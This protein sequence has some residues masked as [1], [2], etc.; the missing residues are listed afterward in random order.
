MK[1]EAVKARL[2]EINNQS[3]KLQLL[4]SGVIV[5][6]SR[7]YIF[8]LIAKGAICLHMGSGLVL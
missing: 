8:Q 1:P 3:F 5:Q 4:Q 6:M 7:A 2:L